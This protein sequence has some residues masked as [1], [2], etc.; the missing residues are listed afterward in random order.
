MAILSR[1]TPYRKSWLTIMTIAL[2]MRVAWAL[3]VPVRPVSDSLVYDQLAWNLASRGAYAWNNGDLTAYWPVGTAFI[4]SVVFGMFGH[5]W[6]PVAAL[7]AIVGTLCVG[8]TMTVARRLFSAAAALAAGAIYAFWPSQIEFTSILASESF[9]NFLLLL[10]LSLSVAG[11]MRSWSVK[12]MLAGACLAGAALVR[13]TAL[14]LV[15]L[16]A[17]AL[18]WS[19]PAQWR[20]VTQFTVAALLAMAVCIAPWTVRNAREL[21]A[22]VLISTNGA[23]NFWMGNNP[24]ATGAYIPL[25]G[26]V[27]GLS[28]AARSKLLGERAKNYILQHPG[29]A[30]TLFLRK[31][32]ITHDRETIG[33]SWNESSLHPVV[34]NI[35]L[36]IAKAISTI[37]WWVALALGATGAVLLFLQNGWRGLLHPALLAWAYFALVHAVTVGADRYHFPSIPFIAMLGGYAVEYIRHKRAS[38]KSTEPTAPLLYSG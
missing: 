11:Q 6:G 15:A 10:A 35:G 36:R 23:A 4:Y 28:E 20:A 7:N 31:L 32:I 13:P 29:R 18:L 26:D 25:P 37:Y 27:S 38:V 5:N 3:A 21:H 12:G 22:P 1:L 30:G 16:L 24:D 34:G 19:A 17:A 2:V 33:I 14:P 9:F 8:L